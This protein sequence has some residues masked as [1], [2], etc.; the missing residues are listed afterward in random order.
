MDNIIIVLLVLLV[1]IAIITLI[2][3]KK[4]IDLVKKNSAK[5]ESLK[6][7]NSKY[8]FNENVKKHILISNYVRNKT[9]LSKINRVE[10]L[11]NMFEDNVNNLALNLEYVME[12]ETNFIEYEQKYEKINDVT[13]P[14][15]IAVTNIKMK[16][17]LF[18]EKR[19][20]KSD[21]L[22]PLVTTD[23]KIISSFNGPEDKNKYE[24]KEIY[25]YEELK[26]IFKETKVTN[27]EGE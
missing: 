11:K 18:L 19:L 1:I 4:K 24:K 23:L 10:L 17:F 20:F 21:K 27:K 25:T 8:T 7:L 13:E 14:E 6:K 3:Y 26:N 15:V 9:A 12:N 5:Y 16:T 22:K 2:I